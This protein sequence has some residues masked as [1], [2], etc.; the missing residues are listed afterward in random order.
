MHTPVYF[1]VPSLNALSK[2]FMLGDLGVKQVAQILL[3]FFSF[4]FLL[5]R[6]PGY[7]SHI[8]KG[9]VAAPTNSKRTI[10]ELV[11]PLGLQPSI[12]T[13]QKGQYNTPLTSLFLTGLGWLLV[14]TSLRFLSVGTQLMR[15]TGCSPLRTDTQW[16]CSFSS[17]GRQG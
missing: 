16:S 3:L 4:L 1:T 2:L 13:K 8:K 12:K 6:L 11:C 9:E 10:K 7:I 5:C 15:A 17:I 14:S